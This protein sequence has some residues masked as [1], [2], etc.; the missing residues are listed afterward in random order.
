MKRIILTEGK[1]AKIVQ[2]VIEEQKKGVHGG[3]LAL[4]DLIEEMLVHHQRLESFL[5]F[6]KYFP[7]KKGKWT[8]LKNLK[9]IMKNLNSIS[10]EYIRTVNENGNTLKEQDGEEH[11]DVHDDDMFSINQRIREIEKKLNGLEDDYVR[12]IGYGD[13]H[14]QT[15]TL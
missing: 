9:D 10:D 7:N 12:K 2:K 11:T 14:H 15:H 4:A 3:S 5:K 6:K 1:L 13:H 8:Q